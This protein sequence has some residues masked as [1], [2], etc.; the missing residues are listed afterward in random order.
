MRKLVVYYSY[1]GATRNLAG[2]IARQSGAFL[3]ELVPLKPYA[4]DYHTAVREARSELERGFCPKLTSGDEPAALYDVVFIGSPN[5]LGRFAPPV[6]SF[7]RRVDLAGKTVVP[8]CTSGGG[9]FGRM[10]EDFRR[11]CPGSRL[12]PG[13]ATAPDF[14][15][16]EVAKWLK[17]NGLR[18]E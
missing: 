12:L 2:E 18:E 1:S 11:E 7:L 13:L 9:G 15:P 16:D 14:S 8:F 10:I 5:W 17:E 6:L 3:R 4:F